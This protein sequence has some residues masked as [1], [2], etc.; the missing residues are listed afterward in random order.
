[1]TRAWLLVLAP[2]ALAAAPVRA[3]EPP[4]RLLFAGT[5]VYAR[6]D[7]VA[8]HR[9]AYAQTV[10]G[11]LLSEDLAPLVK[12]LLEQYPRALQSGLVDS[13]LLAGVTPD[14]LAGMQAEVV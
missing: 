4:E 5:Q 7:G 3:A 8:A 12:A 9:E 2:L 11:K 1:M 14:V 13:K 6:W 10:V